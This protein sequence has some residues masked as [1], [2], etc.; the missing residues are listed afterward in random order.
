MLKATFDG[1]SSYLGVHKSRRLGFI[2]II[3]M[4]LNE[5]ELDLSH[6]LRSEDSCQEAENGTKINLNDEIK[7]NKLISQYE[8][9]I[10]YR[11]QETN[12]SKKSAASNTNAFLTTKGSIK[13]PSLS[14]YTLILKTPKITI[15]KPRQSM[16]V[17]ILQE[18][19]PYNAQTKTDVKINKP[20]KKHKSH[21]CIKSSLKLKNCNTEESDEDSI[22]NEISLKESEDDEEVKGHS[23]PTHQTNFEDG[24]C[25]FKTLKLRK[26]IRK[27]SSSFMGRL[28]LLEE[29]SED[30]EN[31]HMPSFQEYKFP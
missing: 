21:V 29:E 18:D 15:N 30:C 9:S 22:P 3:L 10:Q 4:N 16:K 2:S 23:S 28:G 24:D 12:Q 6:R 26:A 25:D 20:I 5:L 7:V 11:R 14:Q 17:K 31:N 13:T 19:K 8:N 27:L 1:E